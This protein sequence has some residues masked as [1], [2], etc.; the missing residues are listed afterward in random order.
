[1]R[2]R[3]KGGSSRRRGFV[4]IEVDH[5]HLSLP[6]VHAVRVCTEGEGAEKGKDGTHHR[7]AKPNARRRKIQ[8]GVRKEQHKH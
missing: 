2:L 4:Q 1:M 5:G 3:K 6:F 7:E 8:R